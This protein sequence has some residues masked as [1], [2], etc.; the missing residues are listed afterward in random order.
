M[1]RI[2]VLPTYFAVLF[3]DFMSIILIVY[4]AGK[5]VKAVH[6]ITRTAAKECRPGL[7][8]LELKVVAGLLQEKDSEEHRLNIDMTLAHRV[9]FLRFLSAC[10]ETMGFKIVGI[11]ISLD[12]ALV[13]V[14]T[15]V[16]ATVS[17][18]A[19]AIPT[20]F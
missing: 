9:R 1:D 14:V 18:T 17:F 19:A 10:E 13:I 4:S 3:F 2:L 7:K 16:T 11:R 6:S 15:I 12:V 8:C 5:A 20:L